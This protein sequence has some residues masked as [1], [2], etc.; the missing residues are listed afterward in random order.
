MVAPC[1]VGWARRVGWDSATAI[2]RT[3]R[4]VGACA[5]STTAA[6]SDVV[7]SRAAVPGADIEAE[8]RRFVNI[9]STVGARRGA[10][11]VSSEAGD[12]VRTAR[13]YDGRATDRR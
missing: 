8:K 7:R 5:W 3:V 1:T 2:G 10:I 9:S 6:P 12:T 13:A 4:G 11:C